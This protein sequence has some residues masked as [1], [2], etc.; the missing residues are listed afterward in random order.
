[1]TSSAYARQPSPT[2]RSRE[3]EKKYFRRR[4]RDDAD[5]RFVADRGAVALRERS[6]IDRDSAARNLNPSMTSRLQRDIESL[7]ALELRHRQR[8]ILMNR[9]RFFAPFAAGD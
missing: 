4:L 6:F 2:E 9:H 1:M 7:P 8:R 5:F 3:I